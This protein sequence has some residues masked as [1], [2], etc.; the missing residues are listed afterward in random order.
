MELP[1]IVEFYEPGYFDVTTKVFVDMSPCFID[2]AMDSNRMSVYK[3]IS[4][5]S[6]DC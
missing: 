4:I 2:P 3:E 1:N 5:Q 6:S